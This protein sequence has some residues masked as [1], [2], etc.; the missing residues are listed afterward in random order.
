MA[1][2]FGLYDM[3]LR[4]ILRA[5]RQHRG[6][7]LEDLAGPWKVG[8]QASA[9]LLAGSTEAILTPLERAQTL[10]QH[11]HF[12]GHFA[13][14][15]DVMKKLRPLGV[16]E[17]YRGLV[18][19]LL[20]NGPSSVLFFTLRGPVRDVIPAK[21]S[22][23]WDVLR[24]FVSGAVLGATISTVFFP[25]NV[26]KSVMQAQLGGKFPGVVETIRRV[27]Q[28]RGGWRGVFRGVHINYTRSLVSWG[29]INSTYE[30]L[31]DLLGVDAAA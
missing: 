31:G 24:D 19:I 10:L 20:R 3:Y 6:C 5:I 16:R 27:K 26:A 18:P 8:A 21:P 4:A 13:H 28:E 12:N 15:W 25:I 23:F 22:R 9:A 30:I 29:I 17:Y 7:S 1:A 11:R 14:T 2:M